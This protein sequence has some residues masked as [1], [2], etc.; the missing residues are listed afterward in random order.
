MKVARTVLRGGKGLIDQEIINFCV[1]VGGIIAFL[2]LWQLNQYAL[3]MAWRLQDKV[4]A[5]TEKVDELEKDN[6]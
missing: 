6:D 4:K 2:I 3:K 5:L 1:I